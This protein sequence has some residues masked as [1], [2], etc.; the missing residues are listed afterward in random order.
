M[1]C[2]RI[3]ICSSIVMRGVHIRKHT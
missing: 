2:D 1:A 3:M